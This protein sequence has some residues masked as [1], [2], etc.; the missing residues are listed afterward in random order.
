MH[1]LEMGIRLQIARSFLRDAVLR[2]APQDEGGADSLH[3]P[4]AQERAQRARLEACG[5]R[6]LAGVLVLA[7]AALAT[8]GAALCEPLS[9]DDFKAQ[10]VGV[11]LCGIPSTGPVAG[12]WLCTVHLPDGTAIAAGS[13]LLVRGVWEV[14][15]GKI[16][17]RSPDDPMGRRRCVEYEKLGDGRYKNSDGVEFCLGPCPQ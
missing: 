7:S 13:G 11:P 3:R 16:C 14:E 12:K 15:D 9:A 10:L 6:F 8:A 2:I 17:R 1:G 4:H 5:T